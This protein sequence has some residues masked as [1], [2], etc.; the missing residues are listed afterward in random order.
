MKKLSLLLCIAAGVAFGGRFEIWQNHADALYRV[1]EEA[2]I[3]VTYY[4]ADG[5]RAKSGTVDWRLDNFGSKRLGAGQ[6]DLSKENPFFVRGQLDGPDFLR[7]TV[8]CGADRRTWSVGYDVE[9]IRQDV[10]APADFDAYWQ[11]EKARLE[12]EVP[13]DPRCE[14]V[15][16]GPEYDTYKVS[17]ATFN[18][19]RVHGFMTI[20]ADK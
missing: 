19:R 12:R 6:V 2:V 18:Q 15:N 1:G 20:P 4:E 5:S 7:L 3:R 17:F 9:K 10:P 8:A 14:R 11:G 13:L 16:R